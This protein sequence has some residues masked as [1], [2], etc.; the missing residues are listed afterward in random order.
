[1]E[2]R[3]LPNV[4]RLYGLG[5]SFTPL[6]GKVPITKA[7]AAAPREELAQALEWAKAGNV[8]LRTGGNSGGIVVVDVESDAEPGAYEALGLP[9]TLAVRT[10]SGGFHYYFRANGHRIKNSAGKLVPNIDVRGEGGQVVFPGSLHPVTGQPYEFINP[11]QPIAQIPDEFVQQYAPK[12]LKDWKPPKPAATPPP[13]AAPGEHPYLRRALEDE[14]RNVATAPEGT[15]NDTLNTAAFKLGSLVGANALHRDEVEGALLAAASQCGLPEHEARA[16]IRSGLEA[17]TRN[18]RTL[19][20][21]VTHP[22]EPWQ[23]KDEDVPDHCLNAVPEFEIPPELIEERGEPGEKP[24]KG[25]EP[26][27]IFSVDNVVQ[28]FTDER[29]RIV[30]YRDTIYQ[31]D[32]RCYRPLTDSEARARLVSYIVGL[33]RKRKVWLVPGEPGEPP[34]PQIINPKPAFLAHA[35]DLIKGFDVVDYRPDIPLWI[36]TGMPARNHVALENGILNLDTYELLPHSSDCFTLAALPFAYDP[37]A[38]CPGFMRFLNEVTMGDEDKIC[39]IQEVFGYCLQS[40][41]DGQKIFVFIGEGKNGKTV[42]ANV[43]KMLIGPSNCSAVPLENLHDPHATAGMVGKML[44]FSMEWKYIEPQAEGV[45]KAIS[46]GDPVNVNPKNKPLF[47]AVLPTKIVVISNE[48]PHIQDR[49]QGMWRRIHLLPFNYV[50]PEDRRIPMEPL[51]EGFKRE[52]PGIFNWAIEGLRAWRSQKFFTTTQEMN[53]ALD[54]YRMGSST[55]WTWAEENLVVDPACRAAVG[56]LY[57]HYAGW[58]KDTGHK[59]S[60]SVNFGLDLAR[61]YKARTGG[62]TLKKLRIM[63]AGSRAYFYE[64]I[65]EGAPPEVPPALGG[66]G[67]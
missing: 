38:A 27:A 57:G 9:P 28:G 50:V 14:C 15:R 11:D 13:V 24:P 61:W 26:P 34:T 51:L 55:V 63:A 47:A 59:S 30:Y 37:A 43:L 44:N 49:T 53:A 8:G 62:Q 18:P 36:S 7:W 10:G 33:K 17:G 16:A 22:R 67:T 56:D 41:Q 2:E 29:Q 40:S 66:E 19:P 65:I 54:D 64:G 21:S 32:G 25:K 35:I 60:N 4:E 39:A 42:T 3:Y 45:L 20:D 52:L 12:I 31:Y 6:N 58:C 1:M 48:P 5:A 23:P 46:G